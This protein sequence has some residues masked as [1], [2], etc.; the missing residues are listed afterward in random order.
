MDVSEAE[1]GVSRHSWRYIGQQT[2]HGSLK[3][4][5]RC[6]HPYGILACIGLCDVVQ[7]CNSTAVEEYLQRMGIGQSVS[8]HSAIQR[9]LT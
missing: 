8:R 5:K 9:H 3:A 6:V 4:G 1:K 2:L 7:P